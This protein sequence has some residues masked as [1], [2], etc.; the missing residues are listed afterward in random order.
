MSASSGCFVCD[1]D[2]KPMAQS[3]FLPGTSGR[4]GGTR[5]VKPFLPPKQV[6]AEGGVSPLTFWR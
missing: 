1:P 6:V 2:L 5:V 3:R 4:M